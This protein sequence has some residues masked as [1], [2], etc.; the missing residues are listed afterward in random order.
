M[1]EKSCM[2]FRALVFS[3]LCRNGKHLSNIS[4][5]ASMPELVFSEI[6]LKLF[7]LQKWGPLL[8][9]SLIASFFDALWTAPGTQE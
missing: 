2:T 9:N 3:S 1:T 6:T 8:V 4:V 7:F 5:K